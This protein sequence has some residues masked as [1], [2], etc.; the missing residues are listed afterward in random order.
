MRIMTWSLGRITCHLD[1]IPVW[2]ND[3]VGIQQ[4]REMLDGS[5]AGLEYGNS[6]L[7]LTRDVLEQGKYFAD[8]HF[9]SIRR[10][11]VVGPTE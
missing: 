10:S 2:A 3:P 5:E 7:G 6:N 8:G 9:T 1:S 4:Y 11:G